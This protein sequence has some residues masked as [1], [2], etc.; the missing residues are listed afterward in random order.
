MHSHRRWVTRWVI[1]AACCATLVSPIGYARQIQASQ[2]TAFNARPQSETQPTAPVAGSITG[3]AF[4]DYNA[5][6]ARD[7][8]EPGLPGILVTAYDA[9]GATHGSATTANDGSYTLVATGGGPYRIEFTNAPSYLRPGPAG[10][11]NGTTVQFV[12]DGNSININAGF[13][14]PADYV[15]AQP[16]LAVVVFSAGD[17]SSTAAAIVLH[18]YYANTDTAAGLKA[19]AKTNEIGSV[20]GLAYKRAT[21]DLFAAAYTKR[22]VGFGPGGIGAIYKVPASGAATVLVDLGSA[23]GS[24]SKPRDLNPDPPDFDAEAMSKVGKTSF[25]DLDISSDEKT[26]WT[27]NLAN[28]SL[29]KIDIAA[30]ETGPGDAGATLIGT[31]PDPGC[32]TGVARPFALEVKDDVVYVGGVCTGE[33]GPSSGTTNTIQLMCSLTPKTAAG[34][35]SLR[36]TSAQLPHHLRRCIRRLHPQQKLQPP[37]CHRLG[38]RL[39]VM[40]R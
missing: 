40:V 2:S 33:F 34:A 35:A 16:E 26:L 19:K 3:L 12:A 29:Y 9:I 24:F 10:N 39:V 27:I 8:R 7:P 6:G 21:Q 11:A 14:N 36:S 5:N 23:A 18:P 4:R 37:R 38:G 30:A 20:L 31:H 15:A 13:A 22:G 25:G 32:L 17:Q 28:R 1:G